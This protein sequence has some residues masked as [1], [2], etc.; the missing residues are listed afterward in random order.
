MTDYYI[1]SSTGDE[2]NSGLSWAQAFDSLYTALYQF[3]D[4][5]PR[6]LPGDRI[7]IAHDSVEQWYPGIGWFGISVGPQIN[8]EADG[9]WD[10]QSDGVLQIISVDD[11]GDP[12]PPTTW[13]A[14]AR[15]G[16]KS[17]SRLWLS[18]PVYCYGV[19][20]ESD[21]WIIFEHEGQPYAVMDPWRR[22]GGIWDHCT[23]KL[24]YS[25]QTP[26]YIGFNMKRIDEFQDYCRECFHEF[27][28]C[29]FDISEINAGQ[30]WVCGSSSVV[31]NNCTLVASSGQSSDPFIVSGWANLEMYGCDLSGSPSS[32][33]I[34]GYGPA[35][36]TT[37]Y[38]DYNTSG[39][40]HCIINRCKL[41][42]SYAGCFRPSSASLPNTGD[43]FIYGEMYYSANSGNIDTRIFQWAS[44]RGTAYGESTLVRSGGANN[45][46]GTYSVKVV[47][48]SSGYAQPSRYFPFCL[49]PIRFYCFETGPKTF[50]FEILHDSVTDLTDAEVWIELLHMGAAVPG[51]VVRTMPHALTTPAALP[52]GVGTGSWTTTGMSNPRSQKISVTA[53]IDHEQII[54]FQ[55]KIGKLGK[56][57]YIDPLV[58]VS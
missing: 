29:T 2:N 10:G 43:D 25:S 4:Y 37:Y 13:Q 42:S 1:R 17:T 36:V 26:R 45:G 6:A 44:L 57:L 31:L 46:T 55:I 39:L 5:T 7:F 30:V 34:V 47:T 35:Q 27:F 16:A 28:D 51:S 38:P 3:P 56:T 52:A 14:G 41:P 11:T 21:S 15:V 40:A 22:H 24:T 18:G 8:Q 33:F 58:T 50:T 12:Q 53:T 49:K 19:V 9:G 48:P 54:E 23:F 20:F 32:K